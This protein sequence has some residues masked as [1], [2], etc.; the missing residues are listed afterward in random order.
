GPVCGRTPAM[1]TYGRREVNDNDDLNDDTGDVAYMDKILGGRYATYGEFPWM[2]AILYNDKQMCG[3]AVIGEFWIITAAHCLFDGSQR[4][5]K[6]AVGDHSMTYKDT[7]EET[8][9]L[10]TVIINE[11]YRA[12][13]Y[14]FD[15]A[16]AK[17]KPKSNGRGIQ[18]N[19]YVQPICL[20][21]STDDARVGTKFVFSG[22]GWTSGSKNSFG[23]SPTLKKANLPFLAYDKCKRIYPRAISPNVL[24]AGNIN[25]AE[26][27]C[28]G[29]S[30]GPLALKVESSFVLYGIAAFS[31][32]CQRPNYPTAFSSIAKYRGWID[33]TIRRNSRGSEGTMPVRNVYF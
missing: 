26:D 19:N 33:S 29:D 7:N 16:L 31:S 6:I 8:F 28:S 18:F 13:Q 14:D 21:E 9:E 20:A 24:C 27:L 5:Y 3:G 17:I 1:S 25:G 2:V 15:I 11:R 4:Y 22:W 12:R 32:G 23:R 10:Q 30:G